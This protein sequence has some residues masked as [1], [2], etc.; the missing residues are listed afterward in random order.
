LAG[1]RVQAAA[2]TSL[3]FTEAEAGLI[4]GGGGTVE[5]VRRVQ[6]RIPDGVRV[7]LLPLIQW[8]FEGISRAKT[9]QSAFEARRLG[10]LSDADGITMNAA[11]LLRDAKTV[12]LAL[13]GT[14]YRP[15]SP[16][17]IRV[18]GERVRAALY[19][20]LHIA[21]TGGQITVFDEAVGR[22]LAHVMAGGTLPEDA[23]V[24]EMYLFDL[25][26]E[27]FLGLLGEEKTRARLRHLLQ[28]GGP[29]GN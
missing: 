18:G 19:E 11:A 10:Y 5:I 12:A 23:P 16:A 21:R 20:L 13:A 8:A 29:L 22:R 27:A 6:A 9:S 1:A 3:G 4:P 2:E 15:P 28:S 24:T 26:R 25:E 7:D 14:D 17:L